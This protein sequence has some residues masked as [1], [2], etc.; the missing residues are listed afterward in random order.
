MIDFTISRE[1]KDIRQFSRMVPAALVLVGT[2]LW[3]F[4]LDFI[5]TVLVLYGVAAVICLWGLA[6]PATLKPVYLAWSYFT[7]CVAM[8]VTSLVLVLVFFVGFA[9]V[10]LVMRLCGKDPMRR[11]PDPAADSYWIV[12]EPKP[13]DPKTYERQF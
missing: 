1:L 3:I 11:L 2:L 6:S 9:G 13:F 5:P 7:R 12:R 4:K 10:G 8:V